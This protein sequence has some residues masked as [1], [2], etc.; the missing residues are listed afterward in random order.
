LGSVYEHMERWRQA[1]I[2]LQVA[3]DTFIRLGHTH[4]A[5]SA[6]VQQG[7]LALQLGCSRSAHRHLQRALRLARA[8]GSTYEQW[9]AELRLGRVEALRGRLGAAREHF[10]AVIAELEGRGQ[11]AD[12]AWAYAWLADLAAR[13]GSRGAL[14]AALDKLDSVVPANGHE[15]LT[16]ADLAR[17]AFELE[18]GSPEDAQVLARSAAAAFSARGAQLGKLHALAL[19]A[20]ALDA[21]GHG[22]EASETRATGTALLSELLARVPEAYSATFA[23]HPAFAALRVDAVPAAVVSSPSPDEREE[24]ATSGPLGPAHAA[25]PGLLGHSHELRRVGDWVE[26]VAKTDSAVLVRG[27]SGT[28]KE[29]VAEAIHRASLRAKGPFVRVNVAALPDTLLESELF[30]HER[31]AFTGAVA[32]RKGK[33]ELA[34]GGT[35][36]LDEIGD[37]SPKTQVRLLRVLQHQ[38]FERVGGTEAVN[39]DVRV[40]CATNRD[41]E[42]MVRTGEFRLDLYHRVR[43]V[44]IQLPALRS[45]G[46]DALLL[47]R[48][49][50]A[51]LARRDGRTVSFDPAA[52]SALLRYSWPGNVRELENVVRTAYVL[53]ASSVV[54]RELLQ[55]DGG[56]PMSMSAAPASSLGSDAPLPPLD[57]AKRELEVRLIEAALLRTDGNITRAAE[58]L[59]V[60]RPRLSQKVHEY[61]ISIP[62]RELE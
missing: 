16:W 35:L 8:A 60:K 40:V 59:A 58:L 17:G 31:G 14:E 54:P 10:S 52:E 41:L 13:E 22:A 19:Q 36:F 62:G 24:H 38:C 39:V 44:T 21:L 45:R 47:A 50:L 15:A 32:R 23:K 55:L 27:E 20:R 3:Y 34:H 25:L 26:R 18:A 49:F 61:G 37:V 48:H 28:G 5:A 4:M 42:E 1:D 11:S 43:G 6:S 51:E 33:F 9:H 56:P 2:H 30:G 53:C 46:R 7:E 57:E 29:L 12:L